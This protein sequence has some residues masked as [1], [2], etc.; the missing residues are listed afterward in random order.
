MAAAAGPTLRC[1]AA[2]ATRPGASD[3]GTM[4]MQRVQFQV[5]PL[6]LL[7]IVCVT[8]VN[9]LACGCVSPAHLLIAAAAME[10]NTSEN[11]ARFQWLLRDAGAYHGY[12]LRVYGFDW[13]IR[14]SS[15][16]ID[17]A[18]EDHQLNVVT[19]QEWIKKLRP[20]LR[21]WIKTTSDRVSLFG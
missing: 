16:C 12:C 11:I 13:I 3:F 8:A 14:K 2:L 1:E 17:E 18:G 20:R 9:E 6:C 4:G 21:P 10:T 7:N 5:H 15:K 19:L